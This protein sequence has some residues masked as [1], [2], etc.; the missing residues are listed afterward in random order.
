MKRIILTAAVIICVTCGIARCRTWHIRPDGTGEVPDIRTGIMSASDG[1]ALVLADGIYTGYGNTELSYMGKSIVIRSESGD[2]HACIVD[3]EGSETIW[4]RGFL[5]SSG[6][7]PASAILGVTIRNGHSY[8]GA[9]IWCWRS[10][11]T[12]TNVIL[13]GSVADYHGGG[14]YCGGGASPTLINVTFFGNSAEEGGGV[15]CDWG[16]SATVENTIIAFSER[17]GAIVSKD[18]QSSPTFRCCDIYGNVGGDWEGSVFAQYGS[19]GNISLDPLFC[20]VANPDQ[21]YTIHHTSP[22]AAQPGCG[23]IGAAGIGCGVSAITATVDLDPDV[24][25]P[26]S[27]GRW[28]TCY[29]ELPEG[30]DPELIDV[31]TVMLN[32]AVRAETHPTEVDD[33][34]NDGIPDRMVKFTRGEVIRAVSGFGDVEISITGNVASEMFSGADTIRVLEKNL[35]TTSYD[36]DGK[37]PEHL[38]LQVSNH[39]HPGEVPEILFHLPGDSHVRLSVY[40]VKGRLIRGL[41]DDIESFGT[42]SVIWDGRDDHGTPVASGIYFLRMDSESEAATAK[43]VIVR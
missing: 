14:I 33:Y 11:P 5:F 16:S 3:C 26:R 38:G 23:S 10:S 1:D 6:E 8:Q 29:I 27:R 31:P 15:Y 35:K 25:N 13:S 21:P 39:S 22:C 2:P 4:R 12:M 43:A 32:E 19:S 28:V 7:G 41:I 42:H 17:G 34:D 18:Q 9:G 20:L 40:D 30:Y 36:Q 37:G 24:L